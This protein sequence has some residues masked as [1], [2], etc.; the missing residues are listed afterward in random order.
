MIQPN[1]TGSLGISRPPPTPVF[2]GRIQAGS[3]ADVVVWDPEKVRVFSSETQQ[4]ACDFNIFE[5]FRCQGAP[6]YVVSQG[7][8]VVE[9]DELHA[10]QG[11]GK[12][13][14]MAPNCPYVYS[15]MRQREVGTRFP[16]AL[17]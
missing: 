11:V 5:G 12:F 15:A 10:S 13:I 8:V 9:G 6:A 14:P 16:T 4:S 3:D 7:R 2:Q 17:G 1:P